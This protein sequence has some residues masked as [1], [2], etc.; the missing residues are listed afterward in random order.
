VV[1]SMR[2]QIP[3]RL[4]IKNSPAVAHGLKRSGRVLTTTNVRVTRLLRPLEMVRRC[5]QEAFNVSG[6][7]LIRWQ[8]MPGAVGCAEDGDESGSH[9][10]SLKI[11]LVWMV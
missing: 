2:F 9:A 1:P 4:V 5:C 3:R 6:G 11:R 8:W 10:D 7:V